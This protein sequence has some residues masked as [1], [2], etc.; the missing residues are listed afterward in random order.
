MRQPSNARGIPVKNASGVSDLSDPEYR[1]LRKRVSLLARRRHRTSHDRPG[2]PPGQ[3]P[4]CRSGDDLSL[5]G[6]VSAGAHPEL[7][8]L[9]H[10]SAPAAQAPVPRPGGRRFRRHP[11][12]RPPERTNGE[13][14]DLMADIEHRCRLQKV[15]MPHRRSVDRR[16]KR[17]PDLALVRRGDPQPPH[18]RRLRALSTCAPARCRTDR[19]HQD[20][21]RR[22][23]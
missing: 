4:G 7:A 17:F 6:S 10:G 23:R 8:S 14:S 5:D 13:W 1:V 20:R 15:P 9:A 12:V 16:V 18:R 11:C 19:S 22:R 2:Q 21:P 3:G